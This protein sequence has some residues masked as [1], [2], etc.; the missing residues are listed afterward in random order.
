MSCEIAK[1]RPVLPIKKVIGL[2]ELAERVRDDLRFLGHNPNNWQV[3]RKAENG[4]YQVVIVGGGMA[5]MAAAFA[6]LKVGIFNINII[7]QQPSGREGPWSTYARMK[8]L[9]TSK[10][11]I[12]PS[13]GMPS[14]TFQ[15]WYEAQFGS[16]AWEL[17]VKIPTHLWMEYLCWF[18]KML[19]FPIQNEVKLISIAPEGEYLRLELSNGTV[20]TEKLVLATGLNG[21]GGYVVPDFIHSVPKSHWTH[22]NEPIDFDALKGK[23]VAII[24]GGDAGF[25]AAG[26][27]LENGAKSVDLHIRRKELPVE[28][29]T[30][31]SNFV[32]SN[33]EYGLC[34][35]DEKA[36]IFTYIF[37]M[38]LPPPNETLLRVEKFSNFHLHTETDFEKILKKFDFYIL[39]TGPAIDGTKQPEISPFI[40]NILHWNDKGYNHPKIAKFPYL[41]RYFEFLEKTKGSAPFLNKIHCF[42]HASLIS[43]GGL[44]SGIAL[45][46]VGAQLLAQG[47]KNDIFLK[48]TKDEYLSIF[49]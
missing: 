5:G 3:A 8:A 47:I 26:T 32:L 46:G 12:G 48:T 44:G 25:D 30:I 18:K 38:G 39:A 20:L 10:K 4:V 16:F 37:D 34:S 36:E 42:N 1:L 11:W 13:V 6:L 7:D 2:N 33:G 41:G 15:S 27:A 24:G 21:F 45:V 49:R 19:K 35:D 14:L 23:R 40:H 31:G 9:R 22:T 28:N 29:V 43:H 17:L